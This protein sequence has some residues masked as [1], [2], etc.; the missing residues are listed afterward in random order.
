MCFL[1][2]QP[3]PFQSASNDFITLRYFQ[4]KGKVECIKGKLAP[5]CK[6][7]SDDY[8]FIAS[9]HPQSNGIKKTARSRAGGLSYIIDENGE[10]FIKA[11]PKGYV[12]AG[13]LNTNDRDM[14]IEICL[15]S[16]C[17]PTAYGRR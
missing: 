6:L 16:T 7:S 1:K 8:P 11:Y 4:Q 15:A 2:L 10:T 9:L 14:E 13:Y 12:A 5:T 3:N 17:P